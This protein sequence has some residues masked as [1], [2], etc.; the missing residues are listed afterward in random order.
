MPEMRHGA[1][2][3]GAG[4]TARQGIHLPDAS[5]DPQRPARQLSEVRHGARAGRG[6]RGRRYRAA[7]HDAALLGER[8]AQRAARLHGHGAYFGIAQPF[9][10]APKARSYLE[11][12]L[13]TPVVLWG[14]WPFF[15]KF[16][17]SLKNRSPNMYTLIGL[18]VALA[19]VYSVVAVFVPGL[20]PA[21]VPRCMAAR[22]SA[23][24][25]RQL[26]SSS[27][28]VLL[29]EVMQL[30]ALGQTSQAIRQLLA[31]APNTALRI[32]PTVAKWKCRSAKSRWATACES[33]REKRYPSTALCRRLVARRRINDHRRAGS[34]GEKA[35][36]SRDRRAP[37]TAKARS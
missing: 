22:K 12:V 7:R 34:R 31:L 37:S 19:Y 8:A 2:A 13:A 29:G 20:F 18:G 11:F 24:I 30:R 16:W 25:S 28:L 5:G 14:G 27:T 21:R 23:P 4:G 15:H 36:R 10:L 35:G 17:L 32:E 26:R 6:G 1:G 33:G 3:D 9:G